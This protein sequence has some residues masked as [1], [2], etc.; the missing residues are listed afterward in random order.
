MELLFGEEFDRN[1]DEVPVASPE[2]GT[3]PS[4]KSRVSMGG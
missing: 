1:D 2:S 3:G 4:V